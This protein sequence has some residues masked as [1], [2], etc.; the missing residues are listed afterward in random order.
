M[1]EAQGSRGPAG[2]AGLQGDAAW[3]ASAAVQ[4][5]RNGGLNP[6]GQADNFR[7]LFRVERK[8]QVQML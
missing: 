3:R 6:A 4:Q 7:E 8:L 2:A 1:E 5:H